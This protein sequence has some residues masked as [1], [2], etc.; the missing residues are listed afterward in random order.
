[1][2]SRRE[3]IA[4]LL[5]WYEDLLHGWEQP[6]RGA[7]GYF[8]LNA[9]LR[10]PSY[11]ELERQLVDMRSREPVVYWNVCQRYLYAPKVQILRCPACTRQPKGRLEAMIV[12]GL[13]NAKDEP[14][15]SS[16]A[17]KRYHKHGHKSVALAPAHVRSNFA[18]RPNLVLQGIVDMDT[19]WSWKGEIQVPDFEHPRDNGN[20]ARAA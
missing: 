9:C 8:Q 1:M 6:G 11:R 2:T 20:D 4:T 12:E 14:Q 10:H 16:Q 5:E 13:R 7:N 19:H 17:A 3:T 15:G 18:V